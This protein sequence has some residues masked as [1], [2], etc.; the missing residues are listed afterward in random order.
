[1]LILVRV[2][3]IFM[4]V[5]TSCELWLHLICPVNCRV[6]ANYLTA[7]QNLLM[8]ATL[9]HSYS[10]DVS[11]IISPQFSTSVSICGFLVNRMLCFHVL[12]CI[13]CIGFCFRYLDS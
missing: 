2:H 6:F 9:P 12:L 7:P 10:V 13:C 3:F 11:R 8:P 4:C 1:M 5:D